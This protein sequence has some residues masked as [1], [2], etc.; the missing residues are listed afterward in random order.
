MI[1]RVT[2][3]GEKVATFK[4]LINPPSVD[5]DYLFQWPTVQQ[6]GEFI[7]RHI[8]VRVVGEPVYSAT[9]T[10]ELGDFAIRGNDALALDFTARNFY[11]RLQVGQPLTLD[12]RLSD[13]PAPT[14][15][16]RRQIYSARFGTFF[17]YWW[18]GKCL[19]SS[20]RL[21]LSGAAVSS[22]GTDHLINVAAWD[23]SNPNLSEL[24]FGQFGSNRYITWLATRVA[25]ITVLANFDDPTGPT[26]ERALHIGRMTLINRAPQNLA[27]SV[28]VINFSDT[29]RISRDAPLSLQG[30][31]GWTNRFYIPAAFDARYALPALAFS[32]LTPAGRSVIYICGELMREDELT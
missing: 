7:P 8:Y 16:T 18:T 22:T 6:D 10:T 17:A 3:H 19:A 13:T 21:E 31:V 24:Q 28:D 5:S 32:P 14:G 26:S 23:G 25:L 2:A 30:P 29:S 20:S 11:V 1:P 27:N 12:I 4:Q 9:L 15:Y